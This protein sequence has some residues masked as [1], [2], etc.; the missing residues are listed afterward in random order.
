AVLLGVA[1]AK[2]IGVP[3]L[4]SRRDLGHHVTALQRPM[5]RV[6]LRRATMVLANAATVA[7]QLE[8]EEGVP[9]HQLAIVHN[10][11]DIAAFD[12]AARELLAPPELGDG[13]PPTVLN[14]ARMTYPVKGHD[15]LLRAVAVVRRAVPAL[16]VF[17]VGD[18]PREAALRRLTT[19]LELDGVVR[20]VGR[21]DDVPA[22]LVR[23]DLVCHP[24]RMEGLPNAV[25]E[26][27]AAARPIV[28]TA[29][30][31]TP[32]LIQ[33]G[34]HGVL[35]PAES[36]DDL[37]RGILALLSD[38]ARGERMGRAARARIERCFGLDALV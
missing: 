8:H 34:V 30:G 29:V 3:V 11:L 1:A 20:F 10:G 13:G 17:L 4:A 14:V 38:R 16:R 23:A 35:V 36:P 12:A 2:L 27:M 32:E 33:D 5:L 21:R 37:A 9:A 15:D 7:S 18:G 28:A 25:M 19:D 24:S 26:A 22:L 6:A 31:G